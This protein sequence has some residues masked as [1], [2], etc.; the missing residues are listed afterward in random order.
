MKMEE[1]KNEVRDIAKRELDRANAKFPAFNSLPEGWGI[2]QEEVLEAEFE[3]KN[4]RTELNNLEYT[5][6]SEYMTNSNVEKRLESLEKLATEYIAEQI[7]VLAMIYKNLD[8]V[9]GGSN[10]R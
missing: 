7:Q 4:F 1:L 3:R 9:K 2:L 5:L 10:D 8:Y 6:I